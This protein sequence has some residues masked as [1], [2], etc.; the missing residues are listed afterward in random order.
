MSQI[1]D[2]YGNPIKTSS[3]K[4]NQS[5]DVASF[6]RYV[7]HPSLGLTIRKLPRILAAAEQGDLSAQACLFADMQEKDAHLFAEMTKRK[8]ILLTLDRNIEPPE[9]ATAREKSATA[10]VKDWFSA[11]LSVEDIILNGMDA[12]GHGFSAQEIEWRQDGNIWL[13]NQLFMRPHHWFCTLP[14]QGD[15][16][17]LIDGVSMHGAE[18]W[19]GNWLIHRHNARSGFIA[20]SGLFRVLVWPYLFKNYAVRD[21]AE[22]LEIYG[23]PARIAYYMAGTSEEDRDRLLMSLVRLGHDSVAVME[24]GSEV[25]FEAAASG[26]GDTFTMMIDWCEKTMSKAILGGT[27]TTQAD[28]KTSTNALG[29]I[30]NEVRHDLMSSDARQMEGMF[31][32][33][34]QMML[35]VNGYGDIPLHRQ[36]RLVFDTR[37]RVDLDRFSNAVAV[38]VNGVGMETIPVAWVHKK[39]GIPVPQGNEPVLVPRQV[40]NPFA[41][42]SR[43]LPVSP[44]VGRAALSQTAD[45]PEDD[46]AQQAI[47]SMTPISDQIGEAMRQ[48]V[49]PVI[50][51]LSQ[52]KTADEAMNIAAA[53]YPL[54]DDSQLQALLRSAI[55]LGDILGR[56]YYDK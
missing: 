24:Q 13:V 3:L 30:H 47:D 31:R 42:L 48:M 51:A 45:I 9:N 4:K 23:M 40:A 17:R 54:L 10:A 50:A 53:S 22:F 36:P 5:V 49:A 21:F 6:Q 34:I 55:A 46:P 44:G 11:I 35:A 43:A 52:G 2:Q 1:V 41:G 8:S 38:L 14:E 33:L 12:V 7:D 26:T 32:N 56:I 19:P 29:E 39:G 16:L 27:L 25:K 37:E 15:Q 18:L 20:T 28:G